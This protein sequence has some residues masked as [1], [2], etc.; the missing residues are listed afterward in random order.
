MQLRHFFSWFVSFLITR[1]RDTFDSGLAVAHIYIYMCV[2]GMW[3]Y[4]L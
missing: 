3:I 4:A 2:C 1:A